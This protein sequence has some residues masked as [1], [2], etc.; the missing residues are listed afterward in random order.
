MTS[1]SSLI[2]EAAYRRAGAAGVSALLLGLGLLAPRTTLAAPLPVEL[3][4]QAPSGCPQ[5]EAVLARIRS[6]LG[7]TIPSAPPVRAEGQVELKDGS[8]ELRLTTDQEGRRGERQVRSAQCED[9]AGV[10]AVALTL[11]LTS[12]GAD[13]SEETSSA[14]S[15]SVPPP[16][17]VATPVPDEPAASARTET[18]RSVRFLLTAPQLALGL[19]PLPKPTVGVAGGLGLEGPW[20]SLRVLGEWSK[21]QRMASPIEGYGAT[22]D[23]LSA[24]LWACTVHGQRLSV[25]PC[26][27]LSL[28]RLSASG[29]GPNL[30]PTTQSELVGGVGAGLIGRA[31]L[32]EWLALMVG[33]GGQVELSRPVIALGSLGRV[34]QLGP[35]S[36][37]LLIGPEWIF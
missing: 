9:L 29:Y 37:T 17:P 21:A 30:A 32:T 11:L 25:S 26:I 31:K 2:P 19:G 15:P 27:R 36:A 5:K 28:A 18:V 7:K 10:A 23:R 34:R 33:V 35:A 8:F 1:R 3:S 6:L 16:A 14:P 24:S 4:W 20:W 22:V 13:E 12:N